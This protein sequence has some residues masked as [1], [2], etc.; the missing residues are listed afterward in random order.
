MPAEALT[1]TGQVTDYLTGKPIAGATVI[2]RRETMDPMDWRKHRII[3]EQNFATDAAGKYTFTI[4]P[5]QAHESLF[6]VEIEASHAGYT[7]VTADS[8]WNTSSGAAVRIPGWTTRG[9]LI[10]RTSSFTRP[11]RLQARLSRLRENR[12]RE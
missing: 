2:V 1:F 8:G 3:G 5:E 6:F 9:R 7:T 10:G 11:N 4:P 12:P